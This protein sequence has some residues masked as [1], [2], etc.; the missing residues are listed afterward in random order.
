MS[1]ARYLKGLASVLGFLYDLWNS[2]F[3]RNIDSSF[4]PL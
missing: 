3:K 1:L 2:Y 4:I